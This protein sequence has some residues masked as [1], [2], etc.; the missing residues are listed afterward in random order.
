[1]RGYIVGNSV[2]VNRDEV[3]ANEIIHLILCKIYDE[4]ITKQDTF[5]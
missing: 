4:K 2:G 3:I 1:M 5:I